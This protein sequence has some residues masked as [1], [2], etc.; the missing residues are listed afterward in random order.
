MIQHAILYWCDRISGDIEYAVMNPI[1]LLY[2][3]SC[4]LETI[5]DHAHTTQMN[6]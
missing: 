5:N 2:Y 1:L 4:N 3:T 6:T